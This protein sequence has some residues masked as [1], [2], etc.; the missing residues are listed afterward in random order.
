MK[1]V[2]AL[3]LFLTLPALADGTVTVAPAA[4]PVAT[5][6]FTGL[7]INPSGAT[8]SAMV[9]IT[10]TTAGGQDAAVDATLYPRVVVLTA[11]EML[12]FVA[13]ISPAGADTFSASAAAKRLR[14]RAA[15]WLIDNGKL[16]RAANE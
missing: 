13:A 10:W 4:D 7:C 8:S 6:A 15:K 9:T 16:T 12:S 3:L 14:Q 11:A 1:I 2:V 5:W